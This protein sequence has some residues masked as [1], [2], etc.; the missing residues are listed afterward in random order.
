MMGQ[1]AI[2]ERTVETAIEMLGLQE[3]D[4]IRAIKQSRYDCDAAYLTT[5]GDVV[6]FACGPKKGFLRISRS[7]KEWTDIPH[8]EVNT[9]IVARVSRVAMA[10][11][12]SR[13]A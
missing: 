4:A 12:F 8:A 11:Y 10:S 5:S 13:A 7:L 6:R 9:M 3:G 1:V 2:T